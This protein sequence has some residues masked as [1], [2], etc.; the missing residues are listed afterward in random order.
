[1]S[2]VRDFWVRAALALS[3]A[4]PLYFAGVALATRF[5]LIDW[6][7]GFGQLTIGFGPPI[8]LGALI[9]AVLGLLLALVV[10]PRQGRR[11]ALVAL[12]PPLAAAI[13]VALF[14]RAAQGAPPIHDISTDLLDPPTFS[15]EVLQERA[16]IPGSNGVDLSTKRVPKMGRFGKAEGRLSRELQVEAF[17]DLQPIRV[18]AS[19][20]EATETAAAAARKVGLKVTLKDP[21]AGRVE[22]HATSFWYG[23]VDDV[24]IRIRSA[25]A[26]SGAVV[27]IRSTSRVGVSDLGANARR[28]RARV[29]EGSAKVAA[30]AR[31]HR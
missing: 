13:A 25:P 2:A 16:A 7:F 17:P 5:G 27:D 3:L 4:L 1:M 31:A 12:V 9:A 14:L 21:G 19:V 15:A 29:E 10:P 6:R 22:A 24:A 28:V 18:G 26:G 30:E 20:A 23:F 8:I 11:I